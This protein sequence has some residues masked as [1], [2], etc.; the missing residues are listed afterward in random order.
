MTRTKLLKIL[1]AGMAGAALDAASPDALACNLK[2][3]TPVERTRHQELGNRLWRSAL[4]DRRELADGYSFRIDPSKAPLV[5]LAEWVGYEHKCCPFLRFR[6][7]LSE[8]ASV[9]LTL[10]G[11]AGVKQFIESEF[12]QL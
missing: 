2:A 10:S 7:E 12:S 8:D 6:I 3:L 11:R 4:L 5:E 9:W 1:A